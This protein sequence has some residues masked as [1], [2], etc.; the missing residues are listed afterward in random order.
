MV[1]KFKVL[2][3]WDN[4]L[5]KNLNILIGY[6]SVWNVKLIYFWY[7]NNNCIKIWELGKGA[8]KFKLFVFVL[9]LTKYY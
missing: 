6:K 4:S 1:L 7:I 8:F 5:I 9:G 3:F 2:F